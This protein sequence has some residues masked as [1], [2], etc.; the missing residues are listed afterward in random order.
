MMTMLLE[1]GARCSLLTA[2]GTSAR[3]YKIDCVEQL[4]KYVEEPTEL[5]QLKGTT[6]YT[7]SKLVQDLLDQKINRG[8]F[9]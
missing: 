9:K 6:A 2:L 5:E 1:K 7:N 3:N 4:L 8:K